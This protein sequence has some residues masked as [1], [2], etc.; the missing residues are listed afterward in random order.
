MEIGTA[1]AVTTRVFE[2]KNSIFSIR[3]TNVEEAQTEKLCTQNRRSGGK[4][5]N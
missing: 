5:K 4:V 3:P 1:T 2:H